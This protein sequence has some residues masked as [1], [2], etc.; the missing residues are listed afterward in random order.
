MSEALKINPTASAAEAFRDAVPYC[1]DRWGVFKSSDAKAWLVKHTGITESTANATVFSWS[2]PTE[3]FGYRRFRETRRYNAMAASEPVVENELSGT[4]YVPD[5]P[6]TDTE[7]PNKASKISKADASDRMA[8]NDLDTLFFDAITKVVREDG[9]FVRR[10]MFDQMGDGAT[11]R[12]GVAF[13]TRAKKWWPRVSR[14][15]YRLNNEGRKHVIGWQPPRPKPAAIEAVE[16]QPINTEAAN[17]R[18][19]HSEALVVMTTDELAAAISKGLE[20]L[21]RAHA[22]TLDERPF[23]VSP[24]QV[25][26]V[27][28]IP[29]II[30]IGALLMIIPRG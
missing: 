16:Q 10:E 30:I 4:I 18:T 19:T 9:S 17:D 14:G 7:K 21:I 25:I 23:T 8:S 5:W 15:F 6:L 26:G 2:D 22:K 24:A 29:T 20:P 27:L 11:E 3:R 12:W 13:H 1:A 28:A